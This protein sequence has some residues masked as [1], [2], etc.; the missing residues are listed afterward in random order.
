MNSNSSPK[1][2]KWTE[3]QPSISFFQSIQTKK[4]DQN[5]M[6]LLFTYYFFFLEIHA[7]WNSRKA[8]EIL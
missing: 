6:K 5:Q 1:L 8:D 4:T 3:Q 7:F 2:F